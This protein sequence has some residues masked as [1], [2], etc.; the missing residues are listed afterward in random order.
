MGGTRAKRNIGRS[1]HRRKE[2]CGRI[3]LA[4]PDWDYGA[5]ETA[6]LGSDQRVS[7]QQA[8]RH[9]R[10]GATPS[11]NSAGRRSLMILLNE[12]KFR[13]PSPG[14]ANHTI[15]WK[16]SSPNGGDSPPANR[17]SHRRRVRLPEGSVRSSTRP[18]PP[19]RVGC[20][21]DWDTLGNKLLI[22]QVYDTR[23]TS[24]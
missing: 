18:L 13:Q 11:P 2:C 21:T 1:F 15:W 19:C 9:R 4:R 7:P 5:L 8:P 20:G 17:R 10:K 3:H 24:C 6:H 14:H 22:F 16:N 23:R 12:R